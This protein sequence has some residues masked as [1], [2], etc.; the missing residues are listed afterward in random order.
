MAKIE[1]SLSKYNDM[2]AGLKKDYIKKCLDEIEN[3]NIVF[4]NN[5]KELTT[6]E[7]FNNYIKTIN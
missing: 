2:T 1:F 5:T 7:A 3:G 4:V 6:I